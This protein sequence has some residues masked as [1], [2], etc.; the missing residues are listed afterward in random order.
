M[1]SLRDYL[2]KKIFLLYTFIYYIIILSLLIYFILF[3]IYNYM[4]IYKVNNVLLTGSSSNTKPTT[5]VTGTLFIEQDTGIISEWNG[6]SWVMVV[7]PTKSETLQNKSMSGASNTF[8][9]IPS[10]ALPSVA[11]R[12]HHHPDRQ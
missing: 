10:S 1:V 2:L 9:N 8:T 11:A 12:R 4:T 3:F 7:G 5:Y 6:S